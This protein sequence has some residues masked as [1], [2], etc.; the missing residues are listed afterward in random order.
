MSPEEFDREHIIAVLQQFPVTYD[1]WPAREE[2]VCL[3]IYG[4]DVTMAAEISRQLADNEVYPDEMEWVGKA[5][6]RLWWD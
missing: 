5:V 1:I 3:Y 6:L 4:A 2:S